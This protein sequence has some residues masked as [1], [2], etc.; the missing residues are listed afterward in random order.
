MITISSTLG[1]LS[2]SININSLLGGITNSAKKNIYLLSTF[3]SSNAIKLETNG[4]IN[5]QIF[6]NSKLGTNIDSIKIKSDNGGININTI[7]IIV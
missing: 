3:D 2:N 7:T 6:I 1:T 4:G 5:E